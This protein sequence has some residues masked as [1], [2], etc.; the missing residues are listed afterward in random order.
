MIT[1]PYSVRNKPSFTNS[2]PTTAPA[3]SFTRRF[4]SAFVT[5]LRLLKR[6]VSLVWAISLRNV[7]IGKYLPRHVA[8]TVLHHLLKRLHQR[9]RDREPGETL[10]AAV[11]SGV[12]VPALGVVRKG[13]EVR[14][15]GELT[16]K[17][18]SNCFDFRESYDTPNRLLTLGLPAC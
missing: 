3:P 7:V 4:A 13:G 9:V 8:V 14:G 12:R 17:R 15:V 18:G 10:L 2:T 11:R 5:I 6:N 1:G 16:K